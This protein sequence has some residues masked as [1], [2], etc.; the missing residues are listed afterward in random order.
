MCIVPAAV[1]HAAGA[2]SEQPSLQ[3]AYQD[4]FALGTAVHTWTANRDDPFQQTLRQL[5]AHHFRVVVPENAFKWKW[6]HPD[7]GRYDFRD[8]DAFFKFAKTHNLEVVGHVMVWHRAAPQWI[9][10]GEAGKPAS[11][12]QVIQR[13]RDHMA[14]LINRYG[15]G[16]VAWD[17]VNEALSDK[18]PDVLRDSPWRRLLGDD[19]VEIA[20][21]LADELAPNS[22]LI[23]NDYGWNMEGKRR[24]GLAWLKGMLE[25]GVPIDAIGLQAHWSL[26]GPS[27]EDVQRILD[28]VAS[29]GLPLH[30]SELDMNIFRW[31]DRENRPLQAGFP[32]D[33]AYQ[34]AVRYRQWFEIF[35][36]NRDRI[37][38][39]S[40]WGVSDRMS[41]LNHFPVERQNYPLLFDRDARPKPAFGAVLDAARDTKTE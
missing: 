18:G 31:D 29:L 40:F 28:D 5:T 23:Y 21:R 3:E 17:V 27:P 26:H 15:D 32:D 8:A 34:Q 24:R 33:I 11:R 20:F 10:E 6:I 39:V 36:A 12:E 41:W 16:V 37:E 30:I 35:L 22:T 19:Y 38:R 9:F 25:R 13:L 7:R 14:T 2:E 1:I 4:A